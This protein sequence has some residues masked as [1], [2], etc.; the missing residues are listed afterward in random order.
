MKFKTLM[1]IKAVV[2]ISLGLPILLVPK[3]FYGIFGVTLGLAGMF[4]AREY[5][6]SLIG[7]FLLTWI[8][9]K[10]EESSARR[11]IIWA[12]CIYDAIGFVVTLIFALSGEPNLLIWLPV[13]LY[14]F[15]ALAF[16]Y[17][18]LKPPKP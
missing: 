16:G 4:A 5:G 7:N 18:I 1:I 11:G 3:F 12:L 10:A 9:R 2:C 14:L 17:F 13:V 6:A 8:G 15:L